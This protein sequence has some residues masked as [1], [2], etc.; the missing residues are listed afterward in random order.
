MFVSHSCIMQVFEGGSKIWNSTLGEELGVAN[1][2]FIE[3]L[4]QLEGALG[5]KNFFGGE[6]LGFVDILLVPL[7][8]WF[9]A[10]EKFGGFKVEDEC[11]KFSAWLKRCMQRE[12]VVKALPDPDMVYQVVL[13]LRRMNG[14]D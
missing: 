7:T 2:D 9:P 13:M 4:K 14:I 8:T 12:N 5:D 1:K 3:I 6:N 10:Y 11:P